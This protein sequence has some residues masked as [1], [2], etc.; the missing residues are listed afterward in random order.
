MHAIC[1]GSDKYEHYDMLADDWDIE[2]RC[3]VALDAWGLPDIELTTSIDALSG[4]EKT[5]LFLAGISIHRPA[6][7]LLDEPTN[8][9]DDTSRQKLYEFIV[10]SKATIMVVSHDVTLLNLLEETYELSP[11]GL[12]LYG[13]NY[14]FYKAQ[15]EIEEQALAQQVNA[16][17]TAL[18]LACKKRKRLVRNKK[19]V[20][21]KA[22]EI[23]TK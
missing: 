11:K 8:H 21:G 19:S 10:G 3:R 23:K 16:E 12:K 18:K 14:D 5:K 4:G 20:P 22:K 1:N 2:A 6:V 15:K 17:E 9:L 7:V 13:G